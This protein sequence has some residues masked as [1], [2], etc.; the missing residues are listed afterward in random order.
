VQIWIGNQVPEL[1]YHLSALFNLSLT[2]MYP[3]NVLELL[4]CIKRWSTW[5]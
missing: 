3:G 4:H 2:Y 1:S 5:H